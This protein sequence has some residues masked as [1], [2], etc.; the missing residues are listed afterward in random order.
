MSLTP[1]D[2][3]SCL[4]HPGHRFTVSFTHTLLTR[5]VLPVEFLR[6]DRRSPVPGAGRSWVCTLDRP[7]LGTNGYDR[8]HGSVQGEGD[9]RFV[10]L[11]GLDTGFRKVVPDFAVSSG[12]HVEGGVLEQM[13]HVATCGE[14]HT[15]NCWLTPSKTAIQ[16]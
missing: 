1:E 5:N 15:P 13:K 2:Q 11:K 14:F 4:I 8:Y 7:A 6:Y 3:A 9:V 16:H 10:S 12:N